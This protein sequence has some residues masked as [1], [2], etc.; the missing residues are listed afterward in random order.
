MITNL[1]DWLSIVG[2]VAEPINPRHYVLR[3]VEASGRV[4]SGSLNAAPQKFRASLKAITARASIVG[5]LLVGKG[6]KWEPV[7]DEPVN[8]RDLSTGEPREFASG[9]A[10][11]SLHSGG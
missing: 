11:F 3:N 8:K 1:L 5:E 7:L 10:G 6:K 9:N 4:P 2:Q